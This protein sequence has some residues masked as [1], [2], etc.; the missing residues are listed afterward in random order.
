MAWKD[1]ST[2]KSYEVSGNDKASYAKAAAEIR[3]QI[4]SGHKVDDNA[5]NILN[6][7]KSIGVG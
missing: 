7:A 4:S 2:N 1:I 3:S 5:I 6:K